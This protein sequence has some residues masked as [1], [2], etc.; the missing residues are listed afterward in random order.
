MLP[1]PQMMSPGACAQPNVC[2]D[3]DTQPVTGCGTVVDAVHDTTSDGG[4]ADEAGA[5]AVV[6][7]AVRVAGDGRWHRVGNAYKALT[8]IQATQFVGYTPSVARCL[9]SPQFQT[10][11]QLHIFDYDTSRFP[12]AR[13][14]AQRL[15]VDE[16]HLSHWHHHQPGFDPLKKSSTSRRRRLKC[17]IYSDADATREFLKIYG[18]F[19]ESVIAP[20]LS[21]I[22]PSSHI[23]F[24]TDPSLRVVPPSSERVG[25]PHC[26][27]MYKHQ[28]GQINFWIPLVP[29]YGSNTLLVESRP[30][31]GDFQPLEARYGQVVQFYGNRCVHY[32]IPNATPHTRISFDF[33]AIPGPAFDPD[34]KISREPATGKQL[35]AVGPGEYYSEC[36]REGEEE[37]WS[38]IQFGDRE[39]SAGAVENAT[40]AV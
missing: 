6:G 15:G 40:V 28:A 39:A 33:R 38:T 3:P 7:Q 21:S 35:F 13:L 23:V 31:A 29:V 17:T 9:Q 14:A 2:I 8:A 19:M 30:F 32:T 18:Q 25:H 24:Q 22:L 5:V 1:S 11:T 16:E 10:L 26:D 37:M 20:H 27:A 34:P 36:R 12:F 4:D